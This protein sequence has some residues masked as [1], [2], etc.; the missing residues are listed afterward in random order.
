M[1]FIKGGIL[2]QQTSGP[3]TPGTI[4]KRVQIQEISV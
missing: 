3:A 1:I 2:R 4:K